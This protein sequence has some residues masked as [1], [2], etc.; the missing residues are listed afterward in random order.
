MGNRQ[1]EKGNRQLVIW[2]NG[3]VLVLEFYR[4]IWKTS[5][6]FM[7]VGGIFTIIVSTQV[8]TSWISDRDWIREDLGNIWSWPG[9]R[10]D[11][12]LTIPKITRSVHENIFNWSSCC[13]FFRLT[14]P[15]NDFLITL[16]HIFPLSLIFI[17]FKG[18]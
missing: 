5:K 17:K 7:V 8:Q 14:F 12:S 4:I 3:L 16:T 9:D 11:P 1:L 6:S 15:D 10:L 18:N 13:R 2:Q